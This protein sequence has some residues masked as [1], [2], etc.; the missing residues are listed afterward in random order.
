MLLYVSWT[1]LKIFAIRSRYYFWIKFL[2][3]LSFYWSFFNNVSFTE[4]GT[5]IM[6]TGMIKL[7]ELHVYFR[8][9]LVRQIR[10][11]NYYSGTWWVFFFGLS[12]FW[13]EAGAGV[14]LGNDLNREKVSVV[15]HPS[16]GSQT[17][18]KLQCKQQFLARKFIQAVNKSSCCIPC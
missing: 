16:H 13:A 8:L 7:L 6:F 10:L 12:Q 17:V 11:K 1:L 9:S 4:L 14:Q 3:T 2:E 15:Q 5:I 18:L